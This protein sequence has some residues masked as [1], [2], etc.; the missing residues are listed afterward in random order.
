M[1]RTCYIFG[2][3]EYGSLELTADA[4]SDSLIIAADGGDKMLRRWGITPHLAVGDFDSLGR[5]PNDVPV[6]RHPVQK[7]DTDMA[8]AVQQGLER[9]CTR[10]LLY[11]GLGG[12]L[13][14]TVANF[15]LLDFLARQSCP[16]FLLGDGL[17]VTAVHNGALTFSPKHRGTLS[18]F[19]WGG[20]AQGVT[21]EGLHYPLQNAALTCDHPLGVSNEFQGVPARVQVQTG[22]LLAL[23]YPEQDTPLPTIEQNFSVSPESR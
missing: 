11:G 14:H 8:L 19:A 23:W 2:A 16:A 9:G 20:S 5:V 7:D 21:L 12:R 22:T 18:L 1:S 4:L 17:A 13:D 3:G 6:L 15:H 10:F